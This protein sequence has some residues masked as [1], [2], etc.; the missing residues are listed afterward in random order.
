MY[1]PNKDE[2]FLPRI[3]YQDGG[4][5]QLD[6]PRLQGSDHAPV[7]I[8]VIGG[9]VTGL[10]LALHAREAGARVV[11]LE[12]HHIGWGSS[13]RNGGHVPPATKLEPEELIR[14]YG[15][16][17]G[18]RLIDAVASG[19]D[20]LSDLA[21][22]HGIDA[23]FVRS[24]VITA[25][26]TPDAVDRLRKRTEFWQAK[27]V[28]LPFLDRAE[29]ARVIG[30]TRYLGSSLDPRGATVNP[31]AFVRGLAKAATEAGVLI[32]ERS[33]AISY[34]RRGTKWRVSTPEGALTGDM[35][36][37]C[38]NSYSDSL[39]PELGTSIVPIRA[40]QYL[41][42]P[43]P[44]SALDTILPGRQGL[45]DTRR[46]MAGLRIHSSG[47]L[48]FTALGDPF[49]PISKPNAVYARR[50]ITRLFPQLAE[51]KFN[52]WWIGWMA[53]NRENEWKMHELAPGLVSAMG[54]NGRGFP[55]GL[56]LGRELARYFQGATQADL[57]LPF[58]PVE[59][60]PMFDYHAPLVRALAGYYRVRDALDDM[61]Y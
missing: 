43:L 32:Y 28:A 19:P 47:G 5:V 11:V 6:A 8:I 2:P 20:L 60:I 38:T 22:K 17:R 54:C 3:P 12:T 34:D 33:P 50:R 56:L 58:V 30:T 29:S 31:L 7:D 21:R 9:G 44:K 61:I 18:T 25:A 24:G 41:T 48:L 14:R 27:G 53:F 4:G 16:D 59:R 57:I 55:I 51:V 13:G 26:C 35:V 15:P 46:L 39:V 40:Y 23:E 45:T 42:E 1:S 52:Y 10:S 36:A 49:G 37:I